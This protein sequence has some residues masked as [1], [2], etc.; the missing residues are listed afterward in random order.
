MALLLAFIGASQARAVPAESNS[1]QDDANSTETH[2]LVET[3]TETPLPVETV[4]ETPTLTETLTE[5]PL[6]VETSTQMPTP[7]ETPTETPLSV[8]TVT[9]TPTLTETSVPTETPTESP[10]PVETPIPESTDISLLATALQGYW[11]LDEIAG[12]RLDSSPSV[13]H[14]TNHNTVG[15]LPGKAGLAADFEKGQ[16]EYFSFADTSQNEFDPLGNGFSLAGWFNPESLNDYQVIAAKYDLGNNQRAYRLYL[17]DN[18]KVGLVVSPDGAYQDPYRLELTLPAALAPGVWYHLA[19]VF[20]AQQKSLSLYL[21]GQLLGSRPVSFSTVYNSTAPFTL[22]ANLNSETATQFFD[23]LLDEW[24]FYTG[25]LSQADIQALMS[26]LAPTPTPTPT[27]TSTSTPTSTNTPTPTDTPTPTNTPTSTPTPTNTPTPKPICKY[28]IGTEVSTVDAWTKYADIKPGDTVCI[29][30]GS[31]RQLTLRNFKGTVQAP[32]TF[33][34][35]EG[36][37]V[38]DS[39]ASTG[40]LIQNSQ[41]F[42]LTG[43]GSSDEYGIRVIGSIGSGLHIGQK[44]SDFEIDHIG[45]SD[46]PKVGILARNVATCSDGS[47]NEYDF[48]RDGQIQGDLDDLINRANFTQTNTIYHHIFIHNVG[49]EG[50]YLGSSFYSREEQI[51]CASG[52]ETRYDPLL[53]G[54]QVFDNR[55]ENTGWDGI[56]VGSATN[57]CNIHHNQV[58]RSA[59]AQEAHQRGGIMNNPGS[60]CNIYNNSLKE[61]LGPGIFI[62]G[63]GNNQIYD[64]EIINAGQGGNLEANGISVVTGSNP[65][66]SIYIRRNTIVTPKNYGIEYTDTKGTDSRIENN[67]II[68][69]GNYATEGEKAYIQIW[70]L[71]NVIVSNNIFQ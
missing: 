39:T 71:R 40:I 50:L 29:A 11:K 32:I 12:Q 20:D 60:V 6:P 16:K 9:E 26:S 14:L 61:G 51:E 36:Q 21:D 69:P 28:T 46:V 17:L 10:V 41:H 42:R 35:F 7:V 24:R 68:A 25:S 64:N 34:N 45:I 5:T 44:S 23:G 38:I 62:Q 33:I 2:V 3:P 54:V 58:H 56:Q 70:S 8:E 1:W 59:Q 57:D 30:A 49:T 18:N 55:I 15:S 31:R 52:P 13:R 53:S 19:G 37:V 47:T 43:T 27:D 65:G 48:D 4:T 66:N 22:G 67:L 63:N